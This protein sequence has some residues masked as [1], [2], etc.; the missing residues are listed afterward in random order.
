MAPKR[1]LILA[2]TVGAIA[3]LLTIALTIPYFG[4]S[5]TKLIRYR[6]APSFE[7]VDQDGR[8]FKSSS[9]R[10]KVWLVCFLYTRCKGPCP[11]LAHQLEG[12][13]GDAFKNPNARF[14]TI[15]LD[16]EYDTPGVLSTFA[17]QHSAVGGKWLF[18]TG[19]KQTIRQL[20]EFGFSV[21]A[22]DQQD[23][24]NPIIHSTKFVLVDKQGVIRAF[25]DGGQPENN[26]EILSAIRQLEKE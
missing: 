20:A 8:V 4:R 17:K 13:Q 19:S 2:Y 11:V 22:L 15:S 5:S 7:L 24:I 1:T 26:P 21:T 23:E 3:T 14:I 12:L 9:L 16:P 25:F 18:L 10:G 6:E